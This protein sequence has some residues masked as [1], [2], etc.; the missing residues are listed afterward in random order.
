MCVISLFLLQTIAVMVLPYECDREQ[1]AILDGYKYC[2]QARVQ[3][4]GGW[5]THIEKK[6]FRFCPPPPYEFL[7]MRLV[8]KQYQESKMQNT[9]CIV[10]GEAFPF[11]YSKTMQLRLH[12]ATVIFSQTDL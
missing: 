4:G 11:F 9:F 10:Y 3:G 6:A 2:Y 7:D 5:A 12:F 8:K 1:I